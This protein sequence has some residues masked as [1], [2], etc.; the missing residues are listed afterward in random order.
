MAAGGVCSRMLASARNDFNALVVRDD[1]CFIDP[2]NR[3]ADPADG[4]NVFA[5]E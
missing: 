1:S 5:A 3:N 4:S 2:I